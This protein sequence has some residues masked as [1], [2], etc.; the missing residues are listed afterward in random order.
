[1]NSVETELNLLKLVVEQQGRDLADIK[2]KL[3]LIEVEND[4]LRQKSYCGPIGLYTD[5]DG[6]S[7][8]CKDN[9]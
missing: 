7:G 5:E 8:P 1:M 3:G 6:E 4:Y 2:R 9:A